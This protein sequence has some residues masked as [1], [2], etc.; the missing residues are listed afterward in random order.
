MSKIQRN[1]KGRKPLILAGF[2]RFFVVYDEDFFCEILV[3]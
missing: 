2:R 1:R 3:M